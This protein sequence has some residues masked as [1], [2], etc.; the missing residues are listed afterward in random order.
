MVESLRLSEC[1]VKRLRLDNALGVS[2]TESSIPSVSTTA[3]ATTSQSRI[4]FRKYLCSCNLW[5]DLMVYRPLNGCEQPISPSELTIMKPYYTY[6]LAPIT[7][8]QAGRL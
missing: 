1:V 6:D 3:V 7:V 4:L 8:E 5:F 2:L